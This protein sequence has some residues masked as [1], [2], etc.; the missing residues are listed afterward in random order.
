MKSFFKSFFASLLAIIVVVLIVILIGVGVASMSGKKEPIKDGSYLV[1]DIYGDIQEYC[2]PAGIMSEIIGNKPETLQRILGNLKKAAVDDRIEGVIMKMSSSNNAGRAMLQEIRG[3]IKGVQEKGKKV[4]GFSD[5]IDRKTYYLASAC[6]SIFMPPTAYINFLGLSVTTQHIRGTLDK[7]AINP[8]LHK[9]KDYKSA[10]EMIMD[11]KMSKSARE[12]K[13]WI[14]DEF[15]QMYIQ[16]VE[17][18]RGITESEIVAIMEMAALT[19]DQAKEVSLIDS[20]MYWSEVENMLKGA[21]DEL[22]VVSQSEY[23]DISPRT[24]GFKGKKKIAVIHAQGTIGGRKSKV[25]P[26][27]G[28]MMGHESIIEEIKKAREDDDVA[29]IV[30]RVN[31]PGGESLASDLMSYEIDITKKVKPVVVSMVDVAASGGYYIAYKASKIVADPMT[32]TGSIGSISGKMN[33]KGLNDKLGITYDFVEKGPNALMYS[34]FKDFTDK[35]WEIFTENHWKGFNE[36]LGDV[37]DHRGMSFEEAEKLAHGRVWTGR[38][39]KENG[40]VDELGGLSRAIEIAKELAEIAP[41]EKVTLIHYPIKKSLFET[42]MSGELDFATV[43]NHIIY[44]YIRDD[45]A[46]TWNMISSKKVYMMDRM[47]IN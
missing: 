16:A 34:P 43:V 32:I 47:D 10:A 46:E 7:L 44:R 2:P 25:D 35:Q 38:Q 13:E 6:D 33:M 14:L 9:I 27:F 29:A 20:V 3:A 39:G 40:L 1:I 31:S 36:W 42:I 19:T 26:M 37:A 8:Q 28:I 12:N 24:L 21:D 45:L 4:Y 17:K 5:S 18:D 22:I 23:A 15:W 11:K 41:E 30:F